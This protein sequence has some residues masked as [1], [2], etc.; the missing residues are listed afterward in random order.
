MK[1]IIQTYGLEKAIEIESIYLRE[2]EKLLTVETNNKAIL[3]AKKWLK[4]TGII[5]KQRASQRALLAQMG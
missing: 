4:E 3:A 2:L 1:Q 5:E